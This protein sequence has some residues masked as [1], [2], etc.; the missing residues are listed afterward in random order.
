MNRNLKPVWGCVGF[1]VFL[2]LLL[3]TYVLVATNVLHGGW[4]MP[5]LLATM[6]AGIALATT[7]LV[8]RER[9]GFAV[10]TLILA[11]ALPAVIFLGLV[12][13]FSFIYVG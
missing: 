9:K 6:T 10:A 2:G 5:C 12:V 13:F 4:W 11:L 3:L 7:S 8:R 1:G